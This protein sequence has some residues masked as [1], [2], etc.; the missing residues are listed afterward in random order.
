[1]AINTG[2]HNTSKR[3]NYRQQA[4][5]AGSGVVDLNSLSPEAKAEFIKNQETKQAKAEGGCTIEEVCC[6]E[7]QN[8]LVNLE[9]TNPSVKVPTAIVADSE[10]FLPRYKTTGAL[11]ADLTANIT[12]DNGELRI[13][14]RRT[15]VI[16][17]GFSMALPQGWGATVSARSGHAARGLI[18]TNSP[19]QFDQDY[20]GRVKV[21]VSNVGS[22]NPLVIRHGERFAQIKPVPRHLFEFRAV[23]ELDKTD[24]GDN[25]FGS[26][27]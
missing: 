23:P 17:C 7:I 27:G 14:H 10:E 11:C 20:R 8:Q 26:T 15:V 1:M 24:R 4:L 6:A 25:G 18:V 16:D 3:P 21:I 22:E 13:G 19:A 5:D 12:E 9:Y 2:R